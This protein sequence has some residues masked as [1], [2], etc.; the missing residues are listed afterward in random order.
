M[1]KSSDT[2]LKVIIFDR[3]N[4]FAIF[5][6]FYISSNLEFAQKYISPK[7]FRIQF[8]LLFRRF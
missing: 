7:T 4:L 8:D 6:F 2:F 3:A 5:F 1:N